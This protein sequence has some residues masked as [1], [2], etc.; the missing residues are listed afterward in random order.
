MSSTNRLLLKAWNSPTLTAWV[1]QIGYLGRF[2]VVTPLLIRSMSATEIAC[3]YLFASGNVVGSL[4]NGRVGQIFVQ[5]IALDSKKHTKGLSKD[6]GSTIGFANLIVAIVSAFFSLVL[7]WPA[8]SSLLD[9]APVDGEVARDCYI[10]L[11]IFIIAQF[12][13]YVSRR[14]QIMLKGMGYVALTQ[15]WEILSSILSLSLAGLVLAFDL[16]LVA[17]TAAIQSGILITNLRNYFLCRKFLPDSEA[18][19]NTGPRPEILGKL[20]KPVTA[21]FVQSL[22]NTGLQKLSTIAAVSYLSVNI[23]APYIFAMAL[24]IAAIGYAESP[25]KAIF[26]YLAKRAVDASLATEKNAVMQRIL[27]GMLLQTLATLLLL[28]YGGTILHLLKSQIGLPDKT[29]L[30]GLGACMI[31]R[32]AYGYAIMVNAIVNSIDHYKEQVSGAIVTLGLFL[33]VRD[34]TVFGIIAV[35]FLPQFVLLN[36]RPFQS[37]AKRLGVAP[38][39]YFLRT[40]LIPLTFFGVFTLYL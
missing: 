10:A 16:G 29:V 18:H 27:L 17:L 8:V 19:S 39:R 23:S 32:S 38:G 7:C 30:Y 22:S 31:L 15:R 33:L 36:I 25:L 3:W 12:A 9:S 34:W 13:D 14:Y 24:L 35:T 28:V 20:I 5:E 21:G 37:A 6:M 4:L 11:T 26:P 2:F 40:T 1:A